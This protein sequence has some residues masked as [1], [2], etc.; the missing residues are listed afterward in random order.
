MLLESATK[1]GSETATLHSEAR[2]A[3]VLSRL[4]RLPWNSFS[5]VA[6]EPRYPEG[7]GFGIPGNPNPITKTPE[8]ALRSCGHLPAPEEAWGF[9]QSSSEGC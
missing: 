8:G 6:G 5:A 7:S 9:Q 2:A 1:P 4:Q 3:A